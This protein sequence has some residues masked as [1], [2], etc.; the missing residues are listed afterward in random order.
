MR[1]G[2]IENIMQ[3]EYC[4]RC[5]TP[6]TE[7]ETGPL[8][9]GCGTEQEQSVTLDQAFENDKND[10]RPGLI[11]SAFGTNMPPV[12]RDETQTGK[13]HHAFLL[14]NPIANDE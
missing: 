5:G 11:S 8:C 13:R 3:A 2:F 7:W 1:F 10:F 6:L 12:V 9:E 4:H 14:P